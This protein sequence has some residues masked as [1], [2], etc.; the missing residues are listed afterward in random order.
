MIPASVSTLTALDAELA[1]QPIGDAARSVAA[2]LGQRAVVVGDE[3][4]GRGSRRLRIAAGPS[5]GRSRA[6]AARWMARASSGAG[7]SD[8]PRRSS[9]RIC[10]AGAVHARTRRPASGWREPKPS[11]SLR[12]SGARRA[13][14]ARRPVD[15]PRAEPRHRLAQ[16][17]VLDRRGGG[18]RGG[19]RRVGR[20]RR[21]AAL[22]LHWRQRT[23]PERDLLDAAPAEM[24]VHPGDDDRARCAA[25]RARRRLRPSGSA[26]PRAI[27]ASGSR[28]AARG[29]HWS[30]IGRA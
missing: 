6:P 4:V 13:A 7:R 14:P 3:H 1:A 18:A 12:G 30:S 8:D 11:V 24:R 28:L 25:P 23:L 5:S 29:G 19:F 9:T 16:V 10:V 20:G 17:V 27:G 21:G 15:R 22:F 26:S 2:G